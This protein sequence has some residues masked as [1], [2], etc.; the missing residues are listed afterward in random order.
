MLPALEE[1]W[2]KVTRYYPKNPDESIYTEEGAK[3]TIEGRKNVVYTTKYESVPKIRRTFLK[4]KH[5]V[6]EVCG[7]DFEK[8]YGKLGT[9]YIEVHHKK[10]VSEGERTTDLNDD[11]VMLCSN[12][13]KMIHRGIDHMIMVNELKGIIA[14]NA[15]TKE[16]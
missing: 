9:G 8:V 7:F 15:S 12:C 1:L 10:P 5:L 16:E 2:A 11:L 4:G 6:C 14:A 13:H 3:G